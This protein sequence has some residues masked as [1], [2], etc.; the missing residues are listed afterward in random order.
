MS[1]GYI[2][3]LHFFLHVF[4]AHMSTNEIKRAKWIF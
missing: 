1:A 2:E 3:G 4:I